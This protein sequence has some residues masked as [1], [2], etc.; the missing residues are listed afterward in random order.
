MWKAKNQRQ[1]RKILDIARRQLSA[2]A[3]PPK[4]SPPPP[5]PQA[6]KSGGFGFFK[7]LGVT[8]PAV[9]GGILGYAWYDPEFKKQ[10]ESNIPYAKDV[11]EAVLPATQTKA[12]VTS[13]W[14]QISQGTEKASP[15]NTQG[16]AS[17]QPL[18]KE[19]DPQQKEEPRSKNP[20]DMLEDPEKRI[21]EE[22]IAHRSNP[23]HGFTAPEVPTQQSYLP[24]LREID[25]EQML[26][27]PVEEKSKEQST[28]LST[29]KET[30]KKESRVT[31][32]QAV[33]AQLRRIEDEEKADNAALEVAIHKLLTNSES[34]SEEAVKAQVDYASAVRNHTKL[35]RQAMDD[36]SDILQKDAQWEAV[37]IA[38]SEREYAKDRANDLVAEAKRTIEKL[39]EVIG[40]G[41]SSKATKQNPAIVPASKKINE[42]LKDIGGS[43]AQIRQAESEANVMLKYKDLV[44]KGKKQF[45]KEIESLLPDVKIGTGK[46]LSEDELNALIAHAHRRIEQLQK[47]V[48]E[49][50]AMERQRLK[51]ALETQRQED[52]HLTN[53]AV[54]DERARLKQEFDVEQQKME[55]EYLV[56]LEAE[57]RKQL[58]RQA[59]AHSDHI[60]DVLAVQ[61]DQ[62]AQEFN[63]ELNAKL[64][65]E[66]E[67]FQTEVAGWISRLKGIEAAVDARADSEKLAR[68]AQDLWLA[69]IALNAILH[70]GNE[71]ET[72]EKKPVPLRS[73]VEAIMNSGLK[74]PFVETVAKAIP[75]EALDEGVNTEDE[76][77]ARF[78]RVA[79]ICRRLGLVQAPNTSLYKYLVS[80]F[81]S[82]LV[83]DHIHAQGAADELD[84]AKLDNFDL[85][86]Y[87]QY[88]MDRGSLELALKFMTQLSGESRRAASGWITD[89]RLLLETKQCAFTLTAFASATGLA[90][91]F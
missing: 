24:Q 17:L 18:F 64:L 33:E 15:L 47:Q 57:V 40:N 21:T 3:A 84:L 67:K 23:L 78:V 69:C 19:S 8:I 77:K 36:T 38:Y 10:V 63:R 66:R 62:L 81:H 31:D 51:T 52:V 4:P 46:K 89:A 12:P 48:A 30:D 44:D 9:G 53:S 55:M 20:F 88:W 71:S 75:A 50:L 49:H 2:E 6:P 86:A 65:E 11:F 60:K 80:Y 34:L 83:F 42:F 37:A 87:A 14:P 13:S 56:Q 28:A 26:K 32:K 45:Q 74:H 16:D 70:F 91:T 73:K 41:K 54:L 27:Y 79:R 25:L 61:Q 76:L 7:F 39:R 58:A 85:I 43:A 68:S 1:C 35:L 59:A 82:F 22:I 72:D 5:A 90:N 29:E